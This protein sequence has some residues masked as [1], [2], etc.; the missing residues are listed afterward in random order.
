MKH[1]LIK[2]EDNNGI[3][4]NRKSKKERKCN[5]QKKNNQNKTGDPQNITQ[6]SKD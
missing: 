1:N 5:G 4:R 6:E 3:I 2:F